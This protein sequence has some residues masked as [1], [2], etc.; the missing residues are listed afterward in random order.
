MNRYFSLNVFLRR[1][2]GERAQ[3]IPLDAQ[4]SCPNRDG[5][6]SRKGCAFCNPSGSGSGLG[7]KGYS[8]SQQW[9]HWRERM[10][11]KYEARRFLA[12]LQSYSNTHGSTETIR[13][14]LNELR[15]LP[16]LCGVCIGTRPDCLDEEKIALLA[17]LKTRENVKLVMLELG[18]Q[19]SRDDTLL[20]INRG[21][22]A[23]DFAHAAHMA[24]AAGLSVVAHAM[25]GLPTP[26]GREN[27]DDL[28]N[29]T[30]F[31]MRLPVEGIKFHNLYV[32]RNTTIGR[33]WKAG[34]YTPMPREEYIEAV[35]RSITELHPDTV[36]HR[37]HG[38]PASQELMAPDWASDRNA[39]LTD[40][41][42]Y[43][44]RNDMWQGM[45]NG[46]EDGPSAKWMLA[47]KEA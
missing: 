2:F 6:T 15:D 3:K 14:V 47:N 33:W 45:N 25:A 9:E 39:L 10:G 8:L 18:L 31:L 24:A 26:Q 28:A 4:F 46:A 30:R 44:D 12:Y 40:I 34:K 13:T 29:T 19:S 43:L 32:C 36:V 23:A 16:G 35:G 17:D 27:A 42:T 22:T 1:T 37:L 20:H 5:T 38:D 41:R 11:K 7:Y 21:H